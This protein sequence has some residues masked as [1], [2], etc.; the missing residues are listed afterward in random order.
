MLQRTEDVIKYVNIKHR[1]LTV[2]PAIR[3]TDF[4][5]KQ[6]FARLKIALRYHLSVLLIALTISEP[7]R[8]LAIMDTAQIKQLKSV[9]RSIT[10]KLTTEDVSSSAC[11][12]GRALIHVFVG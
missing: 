7:I 12:L 4:L 6:G 3:I 1:A 9:C 10:A 11:T 2:V 5:H 8:V